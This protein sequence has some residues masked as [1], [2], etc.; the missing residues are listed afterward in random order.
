MAQKGDV[1][2]QAF[3]MLGVKLDRGQGP[4][5]KLRN[6]VNQTIPTPFP[7]NESQG[8]YA[9]LRA[10]VNNDHESNAKAE[11]LDLLRKGK[12]LT[13]I[14]NVFRP[15]P[16]GGSAQRQALFLSKR[17]DAVAQL[18]PAAREN[19]ESQQK[20]AELIQSIPQDEL[21]EAIEEGAGALLK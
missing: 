17:P 3:G 4:G 6:M 13:E 1:Q 5:Q 16:L 18:E 8:D 2:R 21:R 9:A 15:K 14:N 10:Y 11:I 19:S 12:T 20:L 7:K